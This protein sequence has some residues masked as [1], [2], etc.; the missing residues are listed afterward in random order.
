MF[1]FDLIKNLNELINFKFFIFEYE[2]SMKYIERYIIGVVNE[3]FV[4]LLMGE[5]Y[6]IFVVGICLFCFGND[7]IKVI[8]V[9][10]EDVCYV[11]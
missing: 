9:K 5:I 8:D 11:V 6:D 3:E 7:F 10:N 2:D 4:K 1:D